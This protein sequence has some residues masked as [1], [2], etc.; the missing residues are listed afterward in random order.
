MRPAQWQDMEW[1]DRYV[2]KSDNKKK[3]QK[4]HTHVNLWFTVE[5]LS[6]E[7]WVK[8]R[9][10]DAAQASWIISHESL[11]PKNI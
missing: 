10:S 6:T 5:M 3:E 9:L 11:A 4:M 1:E 7:L 2:R 8:P